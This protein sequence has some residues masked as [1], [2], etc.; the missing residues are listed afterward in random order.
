M[1]HEERW[2]EGIEQLFMQP[3]HPQASATD[4]RDG[5]TALNGTV[6]AICNSEP[7]PSPTS[8]IGAAYNSDELS[9]QA[10]GFLSNVQDE[11]GAR[12]AARVL[13]GIYP[14]EAK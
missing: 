14:N 11:E 1:C 8:I 2:S 13:V 4:H 7:L 10:A 3:G 5:Q 9:Q 12:Y 6:S